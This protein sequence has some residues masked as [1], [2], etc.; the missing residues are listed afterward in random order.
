MISP[1]IFLV[2]VILILALIYFVFVMYRDRS[3]VNIIIDKYEQKIKNDKADMLLIHQYKL[4]EIE[5]E[6]KEIEIGIKEMIGEHDKIKKELEETSSKLTSLSK[7]RIENIQLTENINR[8]KEQLKEYDTLLEKRDSLIN[9]IRNHTTARDELDKEKKAID[10]EKERLNQVYEQI[11]TKLEKL[12]DEYTKKSGDL[13]TIETS[14]TTKR[15]ELAKIDSEITIKTSEKETLKTNIADAKNMLDK[16]GI[17]ENWD[18]R[19]RSITQAGSLFPKEGTKNK[20]V[21]N[22]KAYL[23][24]I[25]EYMVTKSFVFDKRVIAA[26]HT[27]IKTNNISSLIVNAGLS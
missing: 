12:V 23:E 6:K 8:K 10:Q 2:M 17:K 16:M 21:V 1:I 25:Q 7:D 15:Q 14:L 19:I 3:K 4:L 5:K 22:E 26:F 24:S 13:N 27:S 20:A 9:E 11:K 18:E